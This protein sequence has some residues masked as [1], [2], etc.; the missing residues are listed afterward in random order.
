MKVSGVYAPIATNFTDAGELDPAKYAENVVRFAASKLAGLVVL[1]TNGEFV[2]L[3][4]E[5]KLA[6]V[7]TTREKMARPKLLIVGTEHE[8]TR[9]TIDFTKKSADLG[10]DVA[11]LLNPTY[12]KRDLTTEAL[13]TFFTD[14]ADASPIPVMLYNMPANSGINLPSSMVLKLSAHPNIVGIKDSGANIVQIAEIIAGTGT[15]FSVFAGSGSYLYATTLLGGVGGTLA[16]ANVAPNF[17]ASLFDACVKGEIERARQMQFD[18]M[19][20]NAAVTTRFG[21]GGLKA[22]LD[23]VGLNGGQPRRPILPVKDADRKEIAWIVD[24]LKAKYGDL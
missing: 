12:H 1:G 21:I 13:E 20:L 15:D 18:L 4:E 2:A 9:A 6:L 17:C 23:Y 14:V 10:A 24:A 3:N 11:L 7:K 16:V 19:P 5:E 8:S 22:A